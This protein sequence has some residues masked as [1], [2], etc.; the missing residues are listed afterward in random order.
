MELFPSPQRTFAPIILF[1]PF[2]GGTSTQLKRHIQFVNELGFDAASVELQIP[3]L[4]YPRPPVSRD[5]LLGLKHLW[6]D[7]IEEAISKVRSPMILYSFSSPSASCFEAIARSWGSER[8]Q[9]QWMFKFAGKIFSEGKYWKKRT[10]NSRILGIVCDSG[11]FVNLMSC[12]WKYMYHEAGIKFA[13]LRGLATLASVLLWGPDYEKSLFSDL[14]SI[15]PRLPILSIRG[16]TDKLVSMEA[17]DRAFPKEAQVNLKVLS[18]PEAGHM[19]G[20]KKFSKTY[21]PAVAAFLKNC[22]NLANEQ[23]NEQK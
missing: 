3:N 11:P 5:G 9:G 13:P 6:A 20:L 22:A 1:V 23:K 7:R 8:N 19:D 12:N 18:I 10:D 21:E 4:K 16:W 15:G 14:K 17:M 2:F